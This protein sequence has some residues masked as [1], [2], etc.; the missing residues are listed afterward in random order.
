MKIAEKILLCSAAALVMLL[1]VMVF[2]VI[3]VVIYGL[4][5]MIVCNGVLPMFDV[6]YPITFTQGLGIG[7][8]IMVLRA[9]FYGT[10]SVKV[11]K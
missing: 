9:I 1:L 4:L 3:N 10:N 2:M 8:I 5:S 6:E 11:N 7:V